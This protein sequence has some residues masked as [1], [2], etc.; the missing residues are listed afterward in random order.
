MV[1]IRVYIDDTHVGITHT[2]VYFYFFYFFGNFLFL[3]SQSSTTTQPDH[4]HHTQI[5][6]CPL[7]SALNGVLNNFV[8]VI[9]WFLAFEMLLT[10]SFLF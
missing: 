3:P 6:Q 7:D 2:N 1:E 10:N 4:Q 8:V 9:A 5:L